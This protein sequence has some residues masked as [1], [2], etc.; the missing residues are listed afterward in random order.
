MPD[1]LVRTKT[2]TQTSGTSIVAT[3]DESI[4]L[5]STHLLVATI[6]LAS[7]TVISTP[8]GWT[9]ITGGGASGASQTRMY[10]RQGNSSTNSLSVTIASAAATL[11]ISA[12]K[13]FV[14]LTPLWSMAGAGTSGTSAPAT[15]PGGHTYGVG[16]FAVGLSSTTTAWGSWT[17][18][19]RI[20]SI[21][22]ASQRLDTSRAEYVGIDSNISISWSGA[23]TPRFIGVVMPLMPTPMSEYGFNEASGTTTADS[24]GNGYN[25]TVN[26]NAWDVYGKNGSALSGAPMST[27]FQTAGLPL[28]SMTGFTMMCWLYISSTNADA[29]GETNQLIMFSEKADGSDFTSIYLD[30][31]AGAGSPYKIGIYN[32]DTSD[33]GT[34][35]SVSL[36]T[37]H[38]VVSTGDATSTALYVDGVQVYADAVGRYV[39][40][41]HTILGNSKVAPGAQHAATLQ[42]KI[43]DFRTYSY[44]LSAEQITA[45]M[46]TP[47]LP[48]SGDVPNVLGVATGGISGSGAFSVTPPAGATGYIAV[49]ALG[50]T[51]PDSVAEPVAPAGF[52]LYQSG[53]NSYTAWRIYRGAAGAGSTWQTASGWS[54]SVMVIG[55]DGFEIEAYANGGEQNANPTPNQTAPSVTTASPSL[56]MRLQTSSPWPGAPSGSYP[57]EA[58]NNRHQIF[59]PNS[60]E[61]TMILL[62]SSNQASAGA[63]G[64]AAYNFSPLDG[65][66]V[67]TLALKKSSRP[68]T[69]FDTAWNT[70]GAETGD[71]ETKYKQITLTGCQPGDV[72]VVFGI[73]ENYMNSGGTRYMW[74]VT[75]GGVKT[76]TGGGLTDTLALSQ[77]SDVDFYAGY[78]P[79]I[80]AGDITVQVGLRYDDG[81]QMGV[82]AYLIP[83]NL[84]TGMYGF[85]GEMINDYDGQISLALPSNSTVIYMGGN[86]AA[87]SMGGVTSPSGGVIYRNHL[88]TGAYA[89]W[90]AVWQNQAAGT[91]NYGPSS[92]SNQ[93]VSGI[94]FVMT[95]NA[96][97]NSRWYLGTGAPVTPYRLTSGGLVELE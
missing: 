19:T 79:V 33:T 69:Y 80:S 38:H 31:T 95:S 59:T 76:G 61:G 47:I 34:H 44:K 40:P 26:S 45:L 27:N 46:N 73:A 8:S 65:S 64:T 18:A 90:T 2:T 75:P 42:G 48:M 62:S 77:N 57:T 93:D 53:H 96:P 10:V 84:I 78:A 35:G 56:V 91:R 23:R 92:L 7:T 83:S 97:P 82:G 29:F 16:I 60:D 54:A 81:G 94:T 37:W 30:R 66:T 4:P 63:T 72:I 9:E 67:H 15:V 25:L 85:A 86:W 22:N 50:T 70:S 41:D 39:Y 5:D 36:N 28:E 58:P 68:I 32:D 71:D 13:G 17:N 11:T 6:H 20:G 12:F 87:Q 21:V 51:G 24:S 52:T 14:S 43:D 1:R 88:S 74:D 3:F 49:L 89:A 55:L